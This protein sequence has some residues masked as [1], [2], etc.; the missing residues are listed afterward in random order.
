[1]PIPT[2]CQELFDE[3]EELKQELDDLQAELRSA[4][5]GRKSGL[6][7]KIGRLNVKIDAKQPVLDACIDQ[8]SGPPQPQPLWSSFTGT[9]SLTTDK[10]YT[11]EPFEAATEWDLFFDGLRTHVDVTK[12][13]DWTIDT[14][15]TK[16]FPEPFDKNTTTISRI[17]S[18]T[19]PYG[20][21]GSYSKTDGNLDLALN[22]RFHHSNILAV[23]PESY[24]SIVLSTKFRGIGVSP[25]SPVTA[26]GLVTLAGSGVFSRGWLDGVTCYMVVTGTLTPVP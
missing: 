10:K 4:P 3:M 12:F 16:L 19:P 20:V 15:A 25:G 17:L 5:T 14:T 18:E 13:P 1:M 21:S 9:M 23:P 8:Y 2:E 7:S 26:A 11:G 24:L 6:A 22:L